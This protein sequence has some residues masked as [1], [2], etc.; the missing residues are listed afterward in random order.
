MQHNGWKSR[1]R[2][3]Q[4][5]SKVASFNQCIRLI[6]MA[7]RHGEIDQQVD[8]IGLI[9]CQSVLSHTSHC[10][11]FGGY[12]VLLLAFASDSIILSF[13]EHHLS[14]V[15]RSKLPTTSTCTPSCT[16]LSLYASRCFAG[17]KMWRVWI[18]LTSISNL[19]NRLPIAQSWATF[20]NPISP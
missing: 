15:W 14:I 6:S 20:S 8:N 3:L 1:K 16:P 11:T 13:E 7:N 5:S 12:A 18:W 17:L 2:E 10:C 4:M 19:I 9:V